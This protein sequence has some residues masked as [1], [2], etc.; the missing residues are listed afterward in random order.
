MRGCEYRAFLHPCVRRRSR[1]RGRRPE[2]PPW[3]GQAR[4]QPEPPSAAVRA[5]ARLRGTARGRGGQ[6]GRR[7]DA[8]HHLSGP[9]ARLRPARGHRS[10]D[11]GPPGRD[12]GR[13]DRL[14]QDDADPQDR[15]RAGARSRGPDRPHAAPP[16]RR[17]HRR[18]AHRRG[19]RY[20][21]RRR[22]GLPGAVHRPVQ[23]RDAGQGH[24]RRHP[25]RPDPARPPAPGLRHDHHRRGARAVPQHRLPARVPV[26]AAAAAARPQA[27]HH[28]GHHR[29]RAV[30]GPLLPRRPGAAGRG[31]RVRHRRAPGPGSD[32]RGVRPY[33]PG[34]DPLPAALAGR[35]RARYGGR[36]DAVG[37]RPGRPQE[38]G[39]GPRR[40]GQGP[41]HR[42]HRGLRRADAGGQRRHPG[43][44]LRRARDPRR[45]RR[46]RRASQG[47][48]ARPEAPAARRDPAAV[49][50]AVE[51]G[52]ASR[53]PAARLA[54]HRAGHERGRDVPDRPGHPLRGGPGH[55]AHQ[56]L[57]EADQGAAA[58]DRAGVAGVRQ[59]AQRPLRPCR[60]RH[61]DPPLLGGGLRRTARVHRARDPAYLPGVGAAADDLGGRGQHARRRRPLPLRRAAGHTRDPRRRAAPDRAGRAGGGRRHHAA[62]RG[63]PHPRPAA[64]GP[65]P[66]A[67]GH[68]GLEARRGPR[69]GDR[70][71]RAVDPGPPRAPRRAARAG[72]PAARPVRRPALRLPDLSEPLGVRAGAA[73]AALQL[74]LPAAVQ[75]G[76]PELPADPRVAGRRGAAPRDG[77]AAGDRDVV[78]AAS[79]GRRRAARGGG[80]RR[81]A[82][83]RDV[84]A[85]LG[86]RHHPPVAARRAPVAD[87]HAG[88]RRGQGVRRRA[89]ARGAARDR[90]EA[91]EEAGPQ[92]VRRRPRGAVRDLP[93]VSPVQE[94]ARV[95]HGGRAGRDQPP[96]GPRRQPH[97]ARVGRGPRRA[98]REAHLLRAALVHQAGRGDVHREGAAVRSAHRVR[99][100]RALRQGGPRGRAR[101]VRA[102]R[103][104]AGRV[105]H[106]PP[107]LP[108]QPRP[109]GG[110]RRAGGSLPA[111]R[112]GRGRGRPV[113][114]LRRTCARLRR[115]RGALRPLVVAGPQGD[116]RPAHLHHGAAGRRRL[117]GHRRVP[118]DL[119]PGRALPT[120]HLPVPARLRRRRRHRAR[121]RGRARARGAG[122]VRLDGA[123]APG[124]ADRGDHQVPAQDGAARARTGARRRPRGRRL[125][126]RRGPGLGGHRPGGRHGRALHVGVHACRAGAARR[127]RAARGVGRRARLAAPAAP[128]GDVPGG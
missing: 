87:R 126:A 50:A 84:P 123:R 11:P 92:R 68:R 34:R 77:Q 81:R 28:V 57:L 79:P 62:D 82:R 56:P 102:A 89:P 88:H 96:V 59:P 24:D 3:L 94:A 125:A 70:R 104:R 121:P 29:L 10:G 58:A 35:G 105:D 95:D 44:P 97:P 67:H 27:D 120:A 91:R 93:W 55:R 108:R 6:A 22:R 53:V 39:Q 116:A 45:R 106:A 98:A 51:R 115:L 19:A 117:R 114:L 37:P 36:A 75:G 63:G 118:G 38:E 20:P 113:R 69:G 7:R 8:G 16:P 54:A 107:V 33:V 46:P 71:G 9:A 112:P 80:G 30:R 49:R 127:R 17:A 100:P 25:A 128:P 74:G 5:A 61:R 76:V 72:R 73:A 41:R 12:R 86:R 65:P 52:A 18:G 21:A 1:S 42:H 31:A 122:R 40:R 85:D 99:P 15:A 119:A 2:P 26:A 64:D 43:V 110:G 60:G 66:G 32:R 23:R 101:D 48:C 14:R 78:P 83:G 90:A 124:G 4:R 109:P 103:P 111:A 47:T 13:R